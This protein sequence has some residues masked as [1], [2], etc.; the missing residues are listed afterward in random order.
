MHALVVYES[1]YGN[2]Q[3]IARAVADGLA[4]HMQVDVVVVG[5]APGVIDSD[6]DLLVVGAPTHAHGLSKP[7]T[8]RNAAGTAGPRLVSKHAGLREWLSTV[9][10]GSAS[11]DAAAFDTVLNGPQLLW[12]SA[13]RAA[14]KELRRLGFH[15]VTRPEDFHVKGPLGPVFDVLEAGEV[16]RARRW[17]EAL[18]VAEGD[19]LAIHA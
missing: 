15:I 6:V 2:T 4:S 9:R 1:M 12:G 18:A 14:D 17:G 8:R 11:I 7:D 3:A 5:S 16:E 19:R 10:G 13:A